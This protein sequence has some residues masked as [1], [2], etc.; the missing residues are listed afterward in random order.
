MHTVQLELFSFLLE[1][2]QQGQCCSKSLSVPDEKYLRIFISYYNL[3]IKC[4]RLALWEESHTTIHTGGE[5]VYLEPALADKLENYKLP[6]NSLVT[7]DA[8]E[9]SYGYREACA[10]RAK[11]GLNFPLSSSFQM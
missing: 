4:R 5:I 2:T 10:V 1:N 9:C 7:L 11:G 8:G 3:F 6:A